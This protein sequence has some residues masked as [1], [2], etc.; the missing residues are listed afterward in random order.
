MK[1]AGLQ[2][3]DAK[4]PSGFTDRSSTRVLVSPWTLVLLYH[5]V[6]EYQGK[7]EVFYM[8]RHG[9]MPEDEA[10]RVRH[11]P[12]FLN[13]STRRVFCLCQEAKKTWALG[14]NPTYMNLGSWLNP[15]SQACASPSGA[16][17]RPGQLLAKSW[18]GVALV[19]L[20]SKV[21]FVA[22]SVEAKKIPTLLPR[23]KLIGRHIKFKTCY[24]LSGM[25]SFQITTLGKII[26]N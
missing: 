22:D 6:W 3:K 24:L 4:G 20:N 10:L 7:R 21:S 23:F 19:G 15:T 18:D 26:V 9:C 8:G 25:L 5:S 11:G 12:R 2:N 13:M 16:R 14:A 1:N 17:S